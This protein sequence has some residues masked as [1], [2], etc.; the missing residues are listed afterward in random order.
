MPGVGFRLGRALISA[1]RWVARRTSPP[2]GAPRASIGLALGGGFAR[3]IA[4]IGVLRVFEENRVPVAAIGGVSAGAMVAAAWASG[5]TSREIEEMARTMRF[6]DVARPTLSRMGLIS[7]ERMGALLRRLLRAHTFEEMKMPLAVVATDVRTGEPVV[8][9]DRGDVVA[10][11][12]ASCSYPGLFL[13][14]AIDGRQ[15]VD[16][17]ISMDVPAL[18]V[19]GLGA[20]RVVSVAL[21]APQVIDDPRN[22]LHVVNRCFQILQSHVEGP[23]RRASDIVLEPEVGDFGWDS[24]E[25][26]AALIDAGRGAAEAALP[27]IER[28][29]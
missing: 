17:G 3:A 2:R 8:F 24:F 16:G 13:P 12:R 21:R 14:V 19:R 10:P 27:R 23:W 7:S 18:A 15:L 26:A 25:S 9:R 6:R 11:I 20:T 28:W 1:G 29:M 5:A 4:H 22:M